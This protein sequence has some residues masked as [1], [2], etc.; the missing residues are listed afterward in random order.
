MNNILKYFKYLAL[1]L[2]FSIISC[3]NKSNPVNNSE[4]TAPQIISLTAVKNQIL[5][6]GQ[7]PAIITCNATGGNL[8]YVWQVDLGDIIPMNG[9]H[10]KVSFTGAACCIG[11]KIIKC[12]VSNDKGSDTKNIVI[13]ILEDIKQ[14]EIIS[15]ESDKTQINST[16]NETAN[17]VCYA[18]G[19][20][21]KYN[22]EVNCGN[23][24]L[25]PSDSSKVTYTA[26]T[27]CIG[28]RTIKCTVSNNKGTDVKTTQITILNK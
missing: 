15:I 23:L 3:S 16:T 18:I 2:L 1:F 26:S 12:T 22:W 28:D 25:N 24:A 9:D 10:S 17:I 14:P 11:D 6:G 13:T 27:A 7:D 8:K 19:G 20:H 5:Y 4:T 21:L